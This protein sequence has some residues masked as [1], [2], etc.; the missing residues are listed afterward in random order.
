MAYSSQGD[1][2]SLARGSWYQCPGQNPTASMWEARAVP[3]VTSRILCP[4]AH[5]ASPAYDMQQL[6]GFEPCAWK[7][8]AHS[9][10]GQAGI[11]LSPRGHSQCSSSQSCV[12]SSD[13]AIAPGWAALLVRKPRIDRAQ[14]KQKPS[15][16]QLDQ[17]QP[18]DSTEPTPSLTHLLL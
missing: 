6:D 12:L 10:R 8:E 5:S 3:R 9:E 15:L 18:H 16:T 14:S 17:D 2:L 7:R 11:F 13:A 4:L 1:E